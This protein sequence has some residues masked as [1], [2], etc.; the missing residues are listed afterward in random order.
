MPNDTVL[1]TPEGARYLIRIEA[2]GE[3]RDADGNLVN[4]NLTLTGE[5]TIT[6]GEIRNQIGERS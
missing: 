5:T 3:V 1:E 2:A 6:E 4:P